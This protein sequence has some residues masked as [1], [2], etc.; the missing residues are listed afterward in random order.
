M[1]ELE[2]L[3]AAIAAFNA[4]SG[5]V[6]TLVAALRHPDGTLTVVDTLDRADEIFRK[7][8]EQAQAWL[9]ANPQRSEG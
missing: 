3:L 2:K 7:N 1:N 4:S 5:S 8:E 9:A 6:F